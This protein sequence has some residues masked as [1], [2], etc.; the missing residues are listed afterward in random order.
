MEPT[1]RSESYPTHLYVNVVN[2]GTQAYPAH[3]IYLN[4]ILVPASIIQQSTLAGL[5]RHLG[6]EVFDFDLVVL[7]DMVDTRMT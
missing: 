5:V 6:E 2:P 1:G 3:H 4:L 7:E